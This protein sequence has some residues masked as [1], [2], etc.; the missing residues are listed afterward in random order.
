MASPDKSVEHHEL[1]DTS[2]ENQIR[3]THFAVWLLLFS[4]SLFFFNWKKVEA[5]YLV[6][7]L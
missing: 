5:Q 3:F 6:S 7:F 2:G 4:L 1:W